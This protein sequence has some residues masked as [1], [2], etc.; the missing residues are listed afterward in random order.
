M[1]LRFLPFDLATGYFSLFFLI[2][3][4]HICSTF[5]P[6]LSA[7]RNEY[8]KTSANSSLIFSFP[9]S[10]GFFH[11]KASLSSPA[12]IAMANATFLGSWN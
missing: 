9:T 10:E 1:Y 8:R 2:L 7:I 5:N 4:I 12:S 3:S 11:K 6:H